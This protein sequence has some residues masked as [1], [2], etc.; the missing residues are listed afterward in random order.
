MGMRLEG[1]FR[2]FLATGRDARA[3]HQASHAAA[4]Q[5]GPDHHLNGDGPRWLACVSA[6]LLFLR[7]SKQGRD[8]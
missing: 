2:Y 8:Q 7:L 3:K 5:C 1:R 4:I 6:E